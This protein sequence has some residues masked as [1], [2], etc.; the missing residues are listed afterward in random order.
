MPDYLAA[1]DEL[2]ALGIEQVIVYCVNDPAVMGA[3]AKDQKV[4]DT[5]VTFVSD[6]FGTFTKHFDMELTDSRVLEHGIIGRCK[7]YAM[8]I[9][10]GVV[11]YQA[12]AED[13]EFDPAGDEFPEATLPPAMMAAI[14][15]IQ[16]A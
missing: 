15:E 9:D 2:A 11:K 8:Y 10:D 13:P 1:K 4:V 7:R 5:H 16:E 3:W 14:K 6:P 12:L